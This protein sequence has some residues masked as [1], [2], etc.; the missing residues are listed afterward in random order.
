MRIGPGSISPVIKYLVIA[1]AA[2]FLIQR[3]FSLDLAFGPVDARTI[4]TPF[5]NLS[6]WG[7]GLTPALF[8]KDFPN[9]LYQPLTYMFLHSGFFH[10]FFNMFALWMFGTE[11]EYAFGSK[12]FLKFYIYCGLGGAFLSLAFM[13]NMN[14]PIVGASGA[15][16]GVLAAY[17]LMFPNRYLL[18]FFLFPMKV[19][20]AIPLFGVLNLIAAFSAPAAPKIAHLAHLGG[21]LVGLVYMKFD[22]GLKSPFKWLRSFKLKRKETKLEKKRQ[23]AEEIMKRVDNILDKINEVGIDNIS[24]EDKKFLED[25]SKL[26]SND[27]K[28][29]N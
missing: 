28:R 22:W 10:I 11:I 25:A 9:Y 4:A 2:I 27:D 18:I 3:L 24:R 8:F 1:N 29:A 14:A 23:K 13:S 21:A 20:Y 16:F 5:S 6:G 15:I 12:N 7:L 19:K 26:L 17:W